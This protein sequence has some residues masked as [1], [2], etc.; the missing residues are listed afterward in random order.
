MIYSYD[1][2]V[3]KRETR[4]LEEVVSVMKR[5]AITLQQY[6]Q[7]ELAAN[8]MKQVELLDTLI[9]SILNKSSASY[10]DD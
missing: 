5:Q 8:A 7:T 9:E 4:K 2:A 10:S 6:G 3:L 1:L